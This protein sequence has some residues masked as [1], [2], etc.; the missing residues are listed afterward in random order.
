MRIAFIGFGEAAGALVEGWG[1]AHEGIRAYDIKTDDATTASDMQARYA[2][3]GVVGCVSAAEAVA[4]AELVFSTVT[5]DQAVAAARTAAPHLPKGACWLDLNS[6]APSSKREAAEVIEAAGARYV[7]VAVMAPVYPKRNLVPLLISGPHAAD[8][9]PVLERLPLALRVIDGEVGRASSIKM[10][11]SVMIKGIEALSAECALAAAQA[12]VLDEVVPSLSNNYS[13]VDWNAQIGYNLE[14]A[15][16]HGARRAAEMQEVAKTLSDLGL[17][18]VMCEA[19]VT[20]QRR[21]ASLD[22]ALP[23]DPRRAGAGQVAEI[24]LSNLRKSGG[25]AR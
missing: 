7:D 2:A 13:G 24:L 22:A 4:R 14:R 5:T 17:P 9:A 25:V 15:T 16:V 21:L 19:T 1:Q 11:R 8:V 18:A 23:E 6:C 12:G 3:L 20:W 10:I